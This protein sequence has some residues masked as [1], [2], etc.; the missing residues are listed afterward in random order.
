MAAGAILKSAQLTAAI[1]GSKTNATRKSISISYFPLSEEIKV[2]STVLIFYLKLKQANFP[3][4]LLLIFIAIPC[5][6]LYQLSV[7]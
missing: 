6:D 3:Y 4:P 1:T 7:G 2:F 5:S